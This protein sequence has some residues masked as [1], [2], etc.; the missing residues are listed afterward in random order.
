[1]K[2]LTRMSLAMIAIPLVAML[3]SAR[4]MILFVQ[5]ERAEIAAGRLRF[6]FSYENYVHEAGFARLVLSIVGLLILFIPY[7]KG[8]RWAIVALGIIIFAYEIPVFVFGA[9]PNLG[10][11]PVFQNWHTERTQSLAVVLLFDYS[12]AL[13]SVAGLVCA[14]PRFL[15]RAQ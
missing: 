5:P 8:E 10:T 3:W 12:L 11:W 9:I 14:L 4:W 1:M 13:L 7:R 6:M 15:K 2:I